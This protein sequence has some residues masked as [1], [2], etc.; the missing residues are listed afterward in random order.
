MAVNVI[1]KGEK[2]NKKMP[3]GDLPMMENFCVSLRFTNE[4]KLKIYGCKQ[5]NFN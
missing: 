1:S 3:C 5:N 2:F 4:C